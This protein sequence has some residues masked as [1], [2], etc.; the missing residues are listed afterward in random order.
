MNT[1]LLYKKIYKLQRRVT[2]VIFY[3]LTFLDEGGL[4]NFLRSLI[5][6][7]QHSLPIELVVNRGDTVVQIGTPWPRTID[8]FLKAIG[9]NG[10]LIVFEANPHNFYNLKA[11]ISSN[12]IGN[13]TVIHAAVCNSNGTG[14]LSLSASHDGDHKIDLS[15]ISMDNDLRIGNEEMEKVTVPFVRIDDALRQLDI[16]VFD[17]LSVTVNGAEI[18]VIKGAAETLDRTGVGAR[19]YAKG[20][21]LNASGKAINTELAFR[22]QSLGFVTAITKG[23][24]SS[25]DDGKWLKRAG[26]VFAWKRRI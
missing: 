5:L 17:Y 19:V 1:K 14:E 4:K 11:H 8:R 9:S 13:A 15:D 10:R 3:P 21:A 2:A 16:M 12:S 22:L 24:N 18:E 25:S 7:F 26:D 6:K 20:H 23:E